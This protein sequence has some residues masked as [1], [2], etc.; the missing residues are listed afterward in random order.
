MW[1]LFPEKLNHRCTERLPVP[2]GWLVRSSMRE[3]HMSSSS[4]SVHTVFI[5]DEFHNWK[6][7]KEES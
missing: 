2:G 5:A 7:P 1:E 6:L 4:C 3:S